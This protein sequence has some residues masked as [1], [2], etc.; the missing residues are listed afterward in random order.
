MDE[1]YGIFRDKVEGCFKHIG[2]GS[3]H[4]LFY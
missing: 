1:F 2:E 4:Q 3:S